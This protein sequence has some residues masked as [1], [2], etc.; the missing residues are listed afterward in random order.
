M[1]IVVIGGGPTGV[2]LAGAFAELRAHVL[3]WDFKRIQPE[4]ARIVLI[5][6]S[7]HVLNGFDPK[8]SAYGAAHLSKMGV[9]VKL[10]ERVKEISSGQVVTDKGTYEAENVIWAAGV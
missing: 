4:Q 5:E 1:S 9:E 7:P 8:L 3:R 6:G 10:N 2:E